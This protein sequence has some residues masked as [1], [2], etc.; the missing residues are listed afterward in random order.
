MTTLYITPAEIDAAA[1][2]SLP[3]RPTAGTAF[4]GGGYTAAELKATFDK[5]PKLVATRLNSL[6]TGLSTGK[7]LEDIPTRIKAK[8]YFSDLSSDINNGNFAAYMKIGTET[9]TEY[10]ARLEERLAAIEERLGITG[11]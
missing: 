6:I 2:S 1:V 8:H 7:M 3:T 10:A 4:G 9:L 11:E 5:L